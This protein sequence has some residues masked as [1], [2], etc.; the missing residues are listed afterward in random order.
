MLMCAQRIVLQGRSVIY[1]TTSETIH[2][3]TMGDIVG[4]DFFEDQELQE[5]PRLRR[6]LTTLVRPKPLFY[7]VLHWSD[8]SD[9]LE[10]DRKVLQGI[11]DD[12][13]FAGAVVAEPR[14]IICPDC[15]AQLRVLAVDTGQAIFSSTLAERLRKHELKTSCPVCGAPLSLPIVEFLGPTLV[16]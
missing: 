6:I 15:Q 14:T 7:G 13:D 10:L 11:V 8:G 9:L 4:F 1:L 2:G 12:D 3:E 16:P 5:H